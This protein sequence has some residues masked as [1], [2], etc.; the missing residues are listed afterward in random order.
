MTNWPSTY[1]SRIL[2]I[3]HSSPTSGVVSQGGSKPQ[4]DQRSLPPLLPYG[5]HCSCF[6][7]SDRSA[8][9]K[10]AP[11]YFKHVSASFLWEFGWTS[12]LATIWSKWFDIIF[13][14]INDKLGVSLKYFQRP[15]T[16]IVVASPGTSSTAESSTTPHPDASSMM[17]GWVSVSLW[18]GMFPWKH[19]FLFG[20]QR[21]SFSC[22]RKSETGDPAVKYSH[23]A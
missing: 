17:I 18:M 8:L 6:F 14:L 15:A 16:L 22:W 5:Q 10:C 12:K 1:H 23:V 4:Q 21:K 3:F 11:L 19:H 9:Y 7:G 13:E 20:E 2:K